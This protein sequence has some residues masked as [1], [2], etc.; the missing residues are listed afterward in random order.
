VSVV[1]RSNVG[2][3]LAIPAVVEPWAGRVA[4]SHTLILP[5]RGWER[6]DRMVVLMMGLLQ[7][8]A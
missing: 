6:Q 8:K 1:V 2:C 3:S 4:A 7:Q 5:S